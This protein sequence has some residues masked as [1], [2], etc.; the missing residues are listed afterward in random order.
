MPPLF[1]PGLAAVI[2]RYDL[3]VVDQWGVLH[4]GVAPLPGAREALGRLKEAG[5]GVVLLSNSGKRPETSYRRLEAL[6][7]ERALYDAAVTSGGQ[8][9]DALR[10][11]SAPP[12]D[13]LGGKVHI[14]AWEDDSLLLE[15]LPYRAVPT[16]TQADWVL[17]AGAE[18]GDVAAYRADL[19]IALDRGLPLLVANPDF[20]TVRPDGALQLCPGSIA[21]EYEAMGGT[22]VWHGKPTAEIYA[23][24]RAVGGDGAA[25]A[26]G[27]SLHHDIAGAAGA[28]MASW[29]ITEG[30]HKDELGPDPGP[31]AVRRVAATYNAPP[32]TF[33]GTRF[34]P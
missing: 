9:Y 27:D 24:V 12:Y 30:I 22:A 15:N 3:F 33:F 13:R 34:A 8:L 2:D 16:V 29:L 1:L 20:V 21:R 23:M 5:K 6:G 10:A 25:L 18:R 19:E 11:A 26:V 17:C 7:F 14:F 28:G 4:N 32:P 31:D